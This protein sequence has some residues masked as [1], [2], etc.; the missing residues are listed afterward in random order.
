MVGLQREIIYDTDGSYSQNFDSVV[1]TSAT[2]TAGFKHLAND[3]ACKVPTTG[4]KWNNNFAVA[5]DQTA[6]VRKVMFTNVL[7]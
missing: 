7:V 3:A 1:R 4:A 6:I 2:I 5:C